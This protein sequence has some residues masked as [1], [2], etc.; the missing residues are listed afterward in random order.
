MESSGHHQVE[1]LNMN[2]ESILC[3]EK[4]TFDQIFNKSNYSLFSF[5]CKVLSEFFFFLLF[6]FKL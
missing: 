1:T 3:S 2:L 5:Y 4:A 6:F